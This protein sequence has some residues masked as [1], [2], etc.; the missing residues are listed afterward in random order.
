MFTKICFIIILYIL[1]VIYKS[2][3]SFYFLE[4]Y[5]WNFNRA[6]YLNLKIRVIWW[7]I[8]IQFFN[9]KIWAAAEQHNYFMIAS[10]S[11]ISVTIARSFNVCFW[12][13]FNFSFICCKVITE[14]HVETARILCCS[15]LI[16]VLVSLIQILKLETYKSLNI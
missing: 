13:V 16:C 2:K 1:N 4:S 8:W 14:M 6:S 11:M 7:L 9:N 12:C 3:S 5:F 10:A 15:N